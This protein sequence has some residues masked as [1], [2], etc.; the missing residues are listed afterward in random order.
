LNP[1]C[2][3]WSCPTITAAMRRA[4]LLVGAIFVLL[5]VASASAAATHHSSSVTIALNSGP[6]PSFIGF[7]HSQQPRCF[8]SRTVK[9]LLGPSGSQEV[10][11]E[12]VTNGDG[13]WEVSVAN[14]F[15]AG[16]YQAKAVRKV[17]RHHGHRH[18]CDTA[19][20]QPLVEN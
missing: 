16:T 10:V 18:I 15:R 4:L 2:G 13:S 3:G 8:K 14:N 11:G 6:P 1:I 7:V 20:S 17:Y 19:K 12:D 5:P 9:L